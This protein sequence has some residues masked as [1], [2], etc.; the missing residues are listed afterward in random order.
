MKITQKVR[1]LKHLEKGYSISTFN[2]MYYHG[3]ADLQG[4]IRQIKDDGHPIVA[5]YRK[6]KTRFNGYATV[7]SYSL[8]K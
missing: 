1:V 6:V 4:V 3:I 5:K 8:S 7:K 2:A